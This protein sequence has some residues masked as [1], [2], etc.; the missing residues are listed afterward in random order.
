VPIASLKDTSLHYELEGPE[1]ATV[2]VLSNSLG[3][4]LSLWEP[5]VAALTRY[6]RVLRYDTRG[7]GGSRAPGI[8]Y[9]LD[10][11]GGDVL[12]LLNLLEIEKFHVCG[13]SLG[14]ITA[15]W[16]AIHAPQRVL[17]L[18]P[19]NTA[20]RIGS[21]SSWNVRIEQV[22]EH[23]LASIADATME[24]W[25]TESFRR[26]DPARVE[27]ARRMLLHTDAQGYIAC[28]AAL[29]YADLRDA[30]ASI[31][32][33]ALVVSGTHDPVTPP[34]DGQ[35]LQGAIPS[36]RY[37]ELNAAHISNVEQ[38]EAFLQTMLE[39]LGAL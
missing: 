1:G 35:Y 33:P 22:T 39:F 12:D 14:G 16:L 18:M 23:G 36:A 27:A 34:S 4:E 5:Q 28:C 29:R 25:F 37:C 21:V 20:A 19:C 38:S 10:D 30:V 2:V 8:A 3:T 13:V 15:L 26:S 11:L 6:Y 32:S 9:S 17:S 7:H 31:A 24:R